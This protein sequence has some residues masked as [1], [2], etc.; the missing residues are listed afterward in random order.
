MELKRMTFAAELKAGGSDGEEKGVITGYGSIF[1]NV[2]SY[3]DVVDKGAF[4]RS[5]KERGLPVMLWQ[6]DS[7][8]PIGVY[9]MASEDDN[10]LQLEGQLNMDVAKACEAY[11]L[12]KQGAIKGMSIGFRTVKSYYD[13]EGVRHLSDVDLFEVSLVTFPANELAEVTGIKSDAPKTEREFEIFLRDAGF[14]RNQ[15]KAIVAKGFRASTGEQRE[16]VDVEVIAGLK[17]AISILS[18]EHNGEH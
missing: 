15:A 12:I 7:T 4:D 14:S 13:K 1:G 3:G 5:L 18:G 9:K 8:Q 17:K 10:G 11:S 6:H 16:A 2:D